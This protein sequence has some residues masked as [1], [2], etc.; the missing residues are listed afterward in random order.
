M[1]GRSEWTSELQSEVNSQSKMVG[2][3]RKS[4]FL[5]LQLDLFNIFNIGGGQERK[6]GR[7]E[8][9]QGGKQ[10]ALSRAIIVL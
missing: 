3:I 1:V 10:E 5:N 7:E 4:N 6:M 2:H 8:N 9:R